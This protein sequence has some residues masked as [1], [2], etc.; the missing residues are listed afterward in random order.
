MPAAVRVDFCQLLF[1][2]AA[3]LLVPGHALVAESTVS[4]QDQIGKARSS[5]QQ[6]EAARQSIQLPAPAYRCGHKRYQQSMSQQ[7]TV[8]SSQQ[9][10]P[11]RGSDAGTGIDLSGR[12]ALSSEQ[13]QHQ[14]HAELGAV[15]LTPDTFGSR[16]QAAFNTE[17][18]LHQH[19][20]AAAT[21]VSPSQPSFLEEP[22]AV[23]AENGATGGG[24]FMAAMRSA[25]GFGLSRPSNSGGAANDTGA[26][27]FSACYWLSCNAGYP[28]RDGVPVGVTS[29][30]SASALLWAVERVCFPEPRRRRKP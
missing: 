23:P 24:G 1:V 11:D 20:P 19:Q 3:R 27:F 15:D 26:L 6:K 21:A 7:D 17:S 13:Y 4:P 14:Q 10:L 9:Q 28:N 25:S 30:I 18:P 5:L 29:C 8:I 22:A 16:Q 12:A 2:E